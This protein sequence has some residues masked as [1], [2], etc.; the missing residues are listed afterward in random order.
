THT[1]YTDSEQVTEKT[2]KVVFDSK[3]F[4]YR[5]PKVLRVD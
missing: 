1:G 2:W 5:L 3:G 4:R